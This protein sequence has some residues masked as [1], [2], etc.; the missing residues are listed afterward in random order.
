MRQVHC[1][2][3]DR[4]FELLSKLA[5]ER[6]LSKTALLVEPINTFSWISEALPRF[7]DLVRLVGDDKD[8][9]VAAIKR[10]LGEENGTV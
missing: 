2:V 4:I 7:V 5:K 3:D 8:R 6:T 10:A 1:L 9:I